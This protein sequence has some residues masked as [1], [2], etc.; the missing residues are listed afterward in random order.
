MQQLYEAR[1][2]N[3]RFNADSRV[4]EYFNGDDWAAMGPSR[5]VPNAVYFDGS[6]DWTNRGSTFT[7]MVDE[8]TVTGSFWFNRTGNYT[9]NSY[10]TRF[11]NRF[12]INFDSTSD[13]LEFEMLDSSGNARYSQG[14]TSIT[15]SGWHHLV[16]SID[17]QNP[18]NNLFLLDG[19]PENFSTPAAL[20]S[21]IDFTTADAGI[22]AAANGNSKMQGHLAD[23]W[24]D[25][26]T[27]IDLSVEANRRKF[28]DEDGNPVY[29]G[30]DGSLPTGEA[31][32]IFLSG[33]TENWH[34]NKGTGGGFTEN[35]ALSDAGSA[36]GDMFGDSP[37]DG[38][39]GWWKLDET[40]GTG[41]IDYASGYDGTV[42]GNL[43]P[44]SDSVSGVFGRALH[45][46]G[47]NSYITL[48]NVGLNS[49]TFSF[50]AWVHA[51]GLPQ[52]M[53]VI[54]DRDP[55]PSDAEGIF[56]DGAN[57]MPHW[58]SAFPNSG[59]A[60]P[61][62]E[63]ALLTVTISPTEQK[64]YVV[65]SSGGFQSYTNSG[66]FSA[67]TLDTLEIGRDAISGR[68]FEGAIDDVRIY[69]RELSAAEV[70]ALYNAARCMNPDRFAGTM[71]YNADEQLL[72][73]CD[74]S[75]GNNGWQAVGP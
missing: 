44:A 28:I 47:S 45:F 35:G 75:S 50:T 9:T 51:E 26:G 24:L 37:T 25:T 48:P 33:D 69:D 53:G 36:P 71:V 66:T 16:F 73:Y 4:P 65:S 39:I 64:G 30:S 56:I 68:N 57:L 55:A 70:Q 32:D 34:S 63:W 6:N 23:F 31:P 12:R 13:V 38:L 61:G 10:I 67:D 15:E 59:I 22:G 72:Q 2:A 21:E 52:D 8:Y 54:M 46:D 43:D 62:S 14:T 42:Q 49:N 20:P 19:T 18:P 27:F 74:P 3:L 40:S 5:Y 58:D 60:V 17:M 29:L 7:D 1:N 41:I 11:G